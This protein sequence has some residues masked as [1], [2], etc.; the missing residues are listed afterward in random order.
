MD[1]ELHFIGRELL[2]VVPKQSGLD[3]IR[4]APRLARL[5]EQLSARYKL[6]VRVVSQPEQHLHAP[7]GA[8]VRTHTHQ[9]A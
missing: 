8:H 9:D 5:S 6:P 4:C 7:D 2:L 3:F 1:V